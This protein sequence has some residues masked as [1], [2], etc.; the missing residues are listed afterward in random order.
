MLPCD[1]TTAATDTT[2]KGSVTRWKWIKWSKHFQL[3]VRLHIDI[4]KF[5]HISSV[6]SVTDKIWRKQIRLPT[7]WTRMQIQKSSSILLTLNFW[8]ISWD[9]TPLIYW[10]TIGLCTQGFARSYLTW[11]ELM[12]F[13]F[14]KGPQSLSIDNVVVGPITKLL[15]FT[16]VKNK[17]FLGSVE[18][19][20][21]TFRNY[22]LN[23]F[24]VSQR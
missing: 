23:Y 19:N 6:S 5:R 4:C 13:T 18:T 12:N 17:E 15:L 11:I 8:L 20:T 10:H 24:T 22:D 3:C 21:F 1:P 14:S 16:M 2:N 9:R 7:W